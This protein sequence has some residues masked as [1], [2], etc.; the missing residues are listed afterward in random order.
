VNLNLWVNHYRK[1]DAVI[2]AVGAILRS[3]GLADTVTI[4][5]SADPVPF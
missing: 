3:H 2:E 1:V 4:R 5:V